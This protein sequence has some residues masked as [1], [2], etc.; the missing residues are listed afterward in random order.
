MKTRI[1][2][3]IIFVFISFCFISCSDLSRGKAKDILL[4]DNRFNKPNS[5]PLEQKFGGYG[6]GLYSDRNMEQKLMSNDFIRLKLEYFG[7]AYYDLTPK[8]RPYIY[9]ENGIEYLKLA[10]VDDIDITGISGNDS[11]KTVEFTII[12][13]P[14]EVGKIALRPDQL[15]VH[16]SASFTKYD[17]GWRM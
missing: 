1:L 12:Y 4:G 6:F 11:Y 10:D 13:K 2:F 5:L 17:D 14:N 8:C 16:R 15:N 3:S 9:N 7:L